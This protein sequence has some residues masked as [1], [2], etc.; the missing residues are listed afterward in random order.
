[1]LRTVHTM[2][3]LSPVKLQRVGRVVD[4]C[5]EIVSA[6]GIRHA[7]CGEL[8][9]LKFEHDSGACLG[10]VW[11]MED[12]ICKIPLIGGEERNLSIGDQV[13]RTNELVQTRCGS[14]VPGE[15]MNPLGSFSI[16]SDR[17]YKRAPPNNMFNVS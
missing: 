4:V 2:A 16:A 14:G 5:D 10:F 8:I 15:V 3:R 12:G 13:Y 7:F 11:N 6:S 9:R 17:G 1:M